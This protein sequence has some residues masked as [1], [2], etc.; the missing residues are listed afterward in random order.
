MGFKEV[1]QYFRS[2]G[3]LQKENW[4]K[5]TFEI[6]VKLHYQYANKRQD[7][8]DLLPLLKVLH[9]VDLVLSRNN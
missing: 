6:Q 5:T 9:I 1:E 4:R 7:G 3:A 2:I 8:S